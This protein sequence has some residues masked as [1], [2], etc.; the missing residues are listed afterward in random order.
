MRYLFRAFAAL[1]CRSSDDALVVP[2]PP[3]PMK[4]SALDDDASILWKL[5]HFPQKFA[6]LFFVERFFVESAADVRPLKLNKPLQKK[7]K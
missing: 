2:L 7:A 1:D 4:S 3:K 5:L 6:E